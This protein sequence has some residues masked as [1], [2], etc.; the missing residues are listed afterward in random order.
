[1]P[2]RL[3]L[4]QEIQ[5]R[6]AVI[7]R[8]LHAISRNSQ[9]LNSLEPVARLPSEVLVTI[10]SFF[11]EDPFTYTRFGGL[12]PGPYTWVLVTHVSHTWRRVALQT[13]HLWRI[14]YLGRPDRVD[15][16]LQR[17]GKA[18]LEVRSWTSRR[19]LRGWPFNDPH[20]LPDSISADSLDL[21]LR[22][23]QRIQRFTL[24]LPGQILFRAF[25]AVDHINGFPALKSVVINSQSN[26]ALPNLLSNCDLPL[27]THVDIQGYQTIIPPTFLRSSSITDLRIVPNGP[28]KYDHPNQR[29]TLCSLIEVL[30]YIRKLKRFEFIDISF[31][32]AGAFPTLMHSSPTSLPP[33]NLPH[34]EMVKI[35]AEPICMDTFLRWC[36]FPFSTTVD[37]KARSTSLHLS[38]IEDGNNLSASMISKLLKKFG[39]GENITQFGLHFHQTDANAQRL[40]TTVSLYHVDHQSIARFPP[41]LYLHPHTRFQFDFWY[42]SEN[43]LS[44]PLDTFLQGI[45]L[46]NVVYLQLNS[47]PVSRFSELIA[48]ELGILGAHVISRCAPSGLEALEISGAAVSLLPSCLTT[49]TQLHGH[50]DVSHVAKASTRPRHG[51][52]LFSFIRRLLF[53]HCKRVVKRRRTPHVLP[54]IGHLLD[55]IEAQADLYRGSCGIFSELVIQECGYSGSMVLELVDS[56]SSVVQQRTRFTTNLPLVPTEAR[57]L[58]SYDFPT[59]PPTEKLP[60]DD[61]DILPPFHNPHPFGHNFNFPPAHVFPHQYTWVNHIKRG[62]ISFDFRGSGGIHVEKFV[63]QSLGCTQTY[64]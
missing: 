35:Y 61:L 40:E 47:S 34:L 43:G 56:V 36:S 2:T 29:C 38:T 23:S 28:T 41:L 37:L 16:F 9:Y 25:N 64:C 48:D 17:S 54:E 3:A 4:K 19:T 52:S 7:T 32:V 27:L 50:G 53:T 30:P 8:E 39:R 60:D 6:E 20:E 15:Q 46:E 42:T 22:E 58:P 33:I 26:D 24:H 5:A 18:L 11:S 45:P 1:M 59:P 49:W 55:V 63:G 21:V 12:V 57:P 62:R 13:S 44:R 10:F 14:I 51:P 31:E